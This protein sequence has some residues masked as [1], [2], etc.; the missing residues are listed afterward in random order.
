MSRHDVSAPP[1]DGLPLH[2]RVAAAVGWRDL[3]AR[4]G[5]RRDRPRC[6]PIWYGRPPQANG[7]MCRVPRFDVDWGAAGPLIEEWGITVRSAGRAWMAGSAQDVH[8]GP[9]PLA[10]VCA[11]VL[12]S[13]RATIDASIAS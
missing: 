4:C 12:A 5:C 7:E 3:E 11:A 8:R 2:V 1:V 6:V 13:A 9:T 10:V